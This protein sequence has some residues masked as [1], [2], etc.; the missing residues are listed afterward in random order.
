MSATTLKAPAKF[1]FDVEFGN[2][3][4][5]G[6]LSGN[7]RAAIAD[8]EKIAF[9]EG[10]EAAKQEAEQ[11]AASQLERVATDMKLLIGH[12]AALETQLEREAIDVAAAI[13]RQLAP[14]LIARQPLAEIE[15][16]VVDVL[17]HVRS[18]PHVAVRVSP[19]MAETAGVRLK[20]LAEERGFSSRLVILPDPAIQDG[21]CL[22]EWADGGVSRDM[23]A[24]DARIQQAIQ[25]FLGVSPG[26]VKATEK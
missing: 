8:A 6:D 4:R 12:L 1:L 18:A 25:N 22:I 3:G 26:T 17:S 23:Q 21:N 11:K 9:R 2:G 19:E 10:F 7:A 24:I 20:K 16:L 14:A 15:A 13:A 5:F